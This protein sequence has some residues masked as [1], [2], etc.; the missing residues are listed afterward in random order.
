MRIL[1]GLAVAALAVVGLGA[2]SDDGK[3]LRPPPPGVTAPLRSTST[4]A[5]ATVTSG[6]ATPGLLTL[7]SPDFEAGAPLAADATCAG[8][9]RSPA[10]AWS[11]LPEG[12]VEVAIV[13][14]EPDT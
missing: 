8:A 9:G 11:G 1:I 7:S 12:T 6:P 2:C 4:T 3:D 13:A 10:L 5:A 14:T